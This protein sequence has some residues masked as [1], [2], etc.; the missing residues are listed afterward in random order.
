[1]GIEGL[2]QQRHQLGHHIRTAEH[3]EADAGDSCATDVIVHVTHSYMQQLPHRA[4][5]GRP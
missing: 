2:G 5:V 4:I 3:Q 1:M